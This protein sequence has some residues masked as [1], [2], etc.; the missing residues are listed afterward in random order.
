MAELEKMTD[1]E[2]MFIRMCQK[3]GGENCVRTDAIFHGTCRFYVLFSRPFFGRST[4]A[5]CYQP[6]FYI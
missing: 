4:V 2:E 5:T 1:I 6:F 3:L